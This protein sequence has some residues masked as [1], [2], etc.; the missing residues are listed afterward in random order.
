MQP[1]IAVDI[2][3]NVFEV[4]V[5]VQPGRVAE[6]H[7]LS[8]TRFLRFFGQCQPATVLLEACSSSHHWAREV[9]RLGH[10]V[11]PLPPHLVR[12]YRRPHQKT[13]R[14]DAK[15]LLEAYR[16]EEIRPVP[17]KT[18]AHQAL[19]SLHRLRAGWIATRNR[20]INAV[21]GLLREFGH[22]IPQGARH[23]VPTAWTLLEDAEAPLPDPFRRGLAEAVL[24]IRELEQRINVVEDELRALASQMPAVSHL[25]SVPGIGL[26]TATALVAFVSDIHRFPSGRHFSAYLGLTPREHSTGSTRRL[27]RI[28]KRGDTYLRKLLIHCA[29]SRLVSAKRRNEPPTDALDTWALE[30][31]RRSGHNLATVALANR[32]ARIAW[33]IWRDDRDYE[34]RQAA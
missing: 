26:L 28:S 22:P 21:R 2:A 33:R 8:R 23:V 13:D 30:L 7:R 29:R 3:K 31:E 5:S 32:L 6:R 18:V 20:R 34:W 15:A 24:E 9:E 10:R 16:N 12:P 17:V 25:L 11:L 4:A 27:G 19:T 14:A 1:T